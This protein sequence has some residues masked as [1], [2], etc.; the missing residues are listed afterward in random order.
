MRPGTHID[1]SPADANAAVTRPTSLALIKPFNPETHR[2]WSARSREQETSAHSGLQC[3]EP[4]REPEPLTSGFIGKRDPRD[5]AADSRRLV[6]PTFQY[7]QR[8]D[9]GAPTVGLR[10]SSGRLGVA[11]PD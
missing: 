9:A 8:F 11:H 5:T 7:P 10:P 1:V 2:D 3:T 4:S 6:P